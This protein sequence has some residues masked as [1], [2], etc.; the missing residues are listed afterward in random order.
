[1]ALELGF[2]KMI[3]SGWVIMN[4]LNLHIHGTKMKFFIKDTFNEEILNGKFHF[5]VQQLEEELIQY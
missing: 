3:Y 5:F 1:M 2:L 4:L